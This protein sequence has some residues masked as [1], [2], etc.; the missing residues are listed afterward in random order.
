MDLLHRAVRHQSFGDGIIVAQEGNYLT[1]DFPCGQKKFVYQN[2]FSGFLHALD[3]IIAAAIQADLDRLL[4]AEAQEAASRESVITSA[5]VTIYEHSPRIN[6]AASKTPDRLNVAFKC[7]FCDGGQ[8]SE[9][10]GFAGICSDDMIRHNILREHKVWCSAEECACMSYL[11]GEISREELDARSADGGFVCYENQMLLEWR[12]FA[13]IVQ[14]G[15]NKGRPMKLKHVGPNSLCVLTTREPGDPEEGRYIFAVFLVDDAY[16]GDGREEGFV[17]AHPEYRIA[18]PRRIART[19]LFWR[20][21]ANAKKPEEVAWSSG[22][23]RYLDDR[24][25]AKILRDIAD[26]KMGEPA[27]TLATRFFEHYCRINGVNSNSIGDLNGALIGRK[28]YK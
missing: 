8:S 12:A 18:L 6:R 3:P 14:T 4:A 5:P 19:L 16:E 10:V 9:R 28:E 1:V 25:A 21:H 20:Y 2:A 23:H 11:R 24:Q 7:N 13:G 27:G 22:L 26:K 17:G 15:E